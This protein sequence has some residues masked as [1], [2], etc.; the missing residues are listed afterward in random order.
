MTNK[1]NRK[2]Q[3]YFFLESNSIY[4]LRDGS[5]EGSLIQFSPNVYEYSY[6]DYDH[7]IWGGRYGFVIQYSHFYLEFTRYLDTDNYR[8]DGVFGYGRMIFSWVF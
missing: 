3:M 1:L 5:V 7:F 4:V 8:E 2:F 6:A